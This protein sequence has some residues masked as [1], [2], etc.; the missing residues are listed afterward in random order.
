MADI[1]QN[2]APVRNPVTAHPPVRQMTAVQRFFLSNE[3]GL[4]VLI[5]LF[6]IIFASISPMFLSN[7]SLYA[8]G[9]TA[10]VNIMIGFSMMV[11]IVT[12]GLNLGVGAIGVC[13][14]MFG[15]WLMQAAGLHWLPACFGA[16]IVGALLGATN[17]VMIV[18]SGLHS[19]IITLATMSVMFGAMIFLTQAESFREISPAFSTLGRMK[20]L[21]VLSPMLLTAIVIGVLLWLAFKFTTVGREILAAGANARAAE[22]SGIRVGRMITYAHALSGVLAVVAGLMLVSR[23][24]AAIPS[25]AGQLGQDWLLPAFLGPVLGGNLLTG[26]RISVLG[27]FLGAF[28]VTMLT[29][30]LL[31]MQVGAFW[32]QTYLG[33][34]LLIAVLLDLARRSYLARNKLV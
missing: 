8:M 6:T 20:I 29:T 27:T 17:G 23:T 34:L 3:F 21:A 16:L 24:G 19:F 11:V 12:G 13:G 25:M 4:I 7:F 26:G 28:L 14:A 31:L 30:G 18:K 1:E 5:V 15:G 2:S 9:R 10:A 22:L 32:V 33:L